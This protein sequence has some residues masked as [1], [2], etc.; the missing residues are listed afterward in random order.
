MSTLCF[1][2]LSASLR[3]HTKSEP[4]DVSGP[5]F[6]GEYSRSFLAKVESAFFAKMQNGENAQNGKDFSCGA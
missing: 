3:M 1:S 6:L 5:S 2:R 4:A